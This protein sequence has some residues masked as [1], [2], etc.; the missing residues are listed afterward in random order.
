MSTLLVLAIGALAFIALLAA[1]CG[2]DKTTTTVNGTDTT[3]PATTI[4]ETT[5]VSDST[6]TTVGGTTTTEALSSA[7]ERQSDGSIRG[8]GY[9]SKVW[10]SGGV[11]YI[12]IDYADMLTGAAAQK[13]AEAA[14]VIGPGE[15]LP[16]DY[17]I[18]NTSKKTRDFKVAS[19]VTLKTST[20]NGAMDKPITWAQFISFWKTTPPSGADYLHLSPWW[21]VRVG[22]TV[23]SIEE[24][25]LP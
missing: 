18:Q 23:K 24:Q 20:W 6:T 21:I 17:Y 19:S 16:N 11:R 8:M 3:A 2:G 15:D 13:A 9:I 4:S 22:D 10:E 14:G 7:E 5:T 1:S 12:R 25:Y